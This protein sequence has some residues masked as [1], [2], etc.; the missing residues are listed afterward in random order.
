VKNTYDSWTRESGP[1]AKA[2]FARYAAALDREE[3]AADAYAGLVRRVE[4][5]ESRKRLRAARLDAVWGVG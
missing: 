2:A 1:C 3:E 5:S 4:R